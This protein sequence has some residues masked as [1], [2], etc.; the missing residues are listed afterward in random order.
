MSRPSWFSDEPFVFVLK[1][2]CTGSGLTVK[3]H[4]ESRP[5]SGLEQSK[6][7]VASAYHP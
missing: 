2:S 5:E 1:N 4:F 6:L 7:A 3:A